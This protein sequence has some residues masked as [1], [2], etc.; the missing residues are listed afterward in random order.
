MLEGVEHRNVS[1]TQF[2]MLKHWTWIYF[3]VSTGG[4]CICV[5]SFHWVEKNQFMVNTDSNIC[6]DLHVTRGNNAFMM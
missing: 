3:N 2:I 4:G 1:C 6:S 5:E